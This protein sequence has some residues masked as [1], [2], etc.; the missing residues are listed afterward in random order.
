MSLAHDGETSPSL[1][2]AYRF[3]KAGQ[4]EMKMILQMLRK[5]AEDGDLARDQAM[6]KLHR[7]TFSFGSDDHCSSSTIPP[8]RVIPSALDR[9]PVLPTPS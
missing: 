4:I 2:P 9:S 3:P 5:D 1:N 7:Q 6:K 8:H